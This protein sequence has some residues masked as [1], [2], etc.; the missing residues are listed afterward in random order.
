MKKNYFVAIIMLVI[1]TSAFAAYAQ[2]YQ[3][4]RATGICRDGTYTHAMHKS[5]ACSSH[6]GVKSWYG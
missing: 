1:S 4:K 3:G 5:G 2:P 6:H